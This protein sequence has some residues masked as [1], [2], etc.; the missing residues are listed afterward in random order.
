[1][2]RVCSLLLILAIAVLSIPVAQAETEPVSIKELPG[3]TS[4]VWK[5]TYEAYGRTIDV[6]TEI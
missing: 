6:D 3:I 4:P 2:K 5:Q 1:M